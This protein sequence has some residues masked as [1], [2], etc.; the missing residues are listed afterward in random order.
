MKKAL[1]FALTIAICGCGPSEQELKLK[2]EELQAIDKRIDSVRLYGKA[3]ERFY[4]YKISLINSGRFTEK[5]LEKYTTYKQM[6]SLMKSITD[7]I[8]EDLKKK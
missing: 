1:L 2:A 8:V 3:M 4:D 5:E 7:K 6:D